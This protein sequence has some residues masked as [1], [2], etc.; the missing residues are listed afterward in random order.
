MWLKNAPLVVKKDSRRL[1]QW[2]LI[3]ILTGILDTS[4]S[5][6]ILKGVT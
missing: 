2:N 5:V 4:V 3:A 1:Y 6:E